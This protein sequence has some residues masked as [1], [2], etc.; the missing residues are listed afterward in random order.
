MHKTAESAHFTSRLLSNIMRYGTRKGSR[1]R[2]ERQSETEC[3]RCRR[4]RT[5]CKASAQSKLGSLSSTARGSKRARF[6][7]QIALTD[8]TFRLVCFLP[9]NCALIS[10]LSN[11]FLHPIKH[12]Q[13]RKTCAKFRAYFGTVL[14]SSC[15]CSR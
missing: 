15:S 13:T 12:G 3:A 5:L 2:K 11:R 4:R 10:I 1:T 14:S 7:L 8:P 6:R 9:I